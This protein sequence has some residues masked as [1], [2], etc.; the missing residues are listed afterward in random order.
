MDGIFW[1]TKIISTISSKVIE[2]GNLKHVSVFYVAAVSCLFFLLI[3]YSLYI[4]RLDHPRLLNSIESVGI[5]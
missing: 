5:S 3:V 4:T 1:V 2:T